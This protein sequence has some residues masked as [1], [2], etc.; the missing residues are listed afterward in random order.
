MTAYV[1]DV[2]VT[3]GW[4]FEDEATEQ[5]WLLLAQAAR[6]GVAVPAIWA[7][8][9]GNVLALAERRQRTSRARTEAF[10]LVLDGLR[11]DVE[12]TSSG[13]LLAAVLPLARSTGL[14]TYDASYVDLAQRLRL[15]L[16]TRDRRMAE[17]AK[18]LG[19]PLLSTD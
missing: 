11:I 18:T 1:L 6:E 8:E 9:L 14:T 2:S 17:A 7:Y 5:G 12:A 19:I 10:L 13:H 3:M 4:H 16:A 15:P